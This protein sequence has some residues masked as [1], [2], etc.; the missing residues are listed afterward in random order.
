MITEATRHGGLRSLFDDKSFFLC[1][2]VVDEAAET[3]GIPAYNPTDYE[4]P[5]MAIDISVDDIGVTCQNP[6]QPIEKDATK[7]KCAEHSVAH[8][9]SKHI[10]TLDTY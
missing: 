3:N 7:S 10:I 1:P 8:F 4:A 5:S 2:D 9:Q 6:A